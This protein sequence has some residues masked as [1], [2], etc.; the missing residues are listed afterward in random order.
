[1]RRSLPVLA[2]FLLVVSGG[3][4]AAQ[5]RD[6]LVPI[7]AT[8]TSSDA[9]I[10]G[11]VRD[12]SGT[13]VRGA[14]VLAVGMTLAMVRTDDRGRFSLRLPPGEYVL[15]ATRDGYL[16]TYREPVRATIRAPISRVITLTRL[17]PVVASLEGAALGDAAAAAATASQPPAPSPAIDDETGDSSSSETA[18]RLR[19]LPR[20]VLRDESGIAAWAEDPAVFGGTRAAA[21]LSDVSAPHTTASAW[22]TDADLTGHVD[23]LTSSSLSA[24][25]LSAPVE[26]PRGIAYVVLGAPVGTL[27]DWSVRAAMTAGDLTS[28]TL[29]GEY[30][31]RDTREHAFRT[32]VAYSAQVVAPGA[33][34]PLVAASS[35]AR[36]VGGAYAADRWT[37]ASGLELDY[38]VKLD[39]YDYLTTP[40]LLSGTTGLRMS[41]APALT[42]VANAGS[43]MVA[44]G[45]D[46]FLPPSTAG[47]WLPPE[48][49]FSPLDLD[50]VLEP[51]RV[52]HYDF[53]L[54]TRLGG[55]AVVHAGRFSEMTT[56]QIATIFGLAGG[57][58]PG[59]YYVSSPGTVRVD[60]WAVG[61]A[62]PL[63]RHVQGAVDYRAARADWLVIASPGRLASVAPSLARTGI[64]AG[65]DLTTSMRAD[66]PATSTKVNVA[67]RVNTAFASASQGQPLLSGRFKIEV[68]QLL[69]FQPLGRGELNLLVSARTLLR[70]VTDE[71]AY[72]DELL[73]INP[74]LRVTCGLQMRF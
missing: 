12:Q 63:S 27:G 9:Q 10:M 34:T 37:V 56:D 26:W 16:S 4:V 23:F 29:L 49:T 46:E 45:A 70:D 15:R 72:Y 66:L 54:E 1:M 40:N 44:P 8:L 58:Q 60:G 7:S 22:L 13:A 53:G 39:R 2:A 25:S 5:P 52:N 24:S 14:S 36:R 71:G 32:G 35:L 59:H 21:G 48:R 42:F 65:H 69:P 57:N 30:Q 68:E 41:I 64:E 73:V 3:R 61:V 62:G 17:A 20:T 18:W 51:E 6:R 33:D 50:G 11:T 38:G 74:P 31:A 43:R 67:Y 47:T 19:H 55:H 28:Y